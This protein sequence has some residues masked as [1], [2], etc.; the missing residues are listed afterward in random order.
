[1]VFICL[2]WALVA[3]YQLQSEQEDI[4]KEAVGRRPRCPSLPEQTQDLVIVFTRGDYDLFHMAECALLMRV[5][6]KTRPPGIGTH[7]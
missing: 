4:G 7:P 3:A 2:K 6:I 5:N 1:M